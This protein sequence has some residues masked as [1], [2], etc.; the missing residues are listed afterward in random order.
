MRLGVAAARRAFVG[1][2]SLITEF[3]RRIDGRWMA[4][5]FVVDN[6]ERRRKEICSG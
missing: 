4:K 6:I 1:L 2:D 3:A 5:D